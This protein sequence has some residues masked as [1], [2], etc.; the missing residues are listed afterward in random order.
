[1]PILS[2]L[3]EVGERRSPLRRRKAGHRRP[4]DLVRE[5]KADADIVR[6]H[7]RISVLRDPRGVRLPYKVLPGGRRQIMSGKAPPATTIFARRQE[8]WSGARV[9]IRDTGLMIGYRQS[10]I[11]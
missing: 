8:L 10:S 3:S 9:D 6:A 1:M 4:A 11:T 5:L 2:R 7:D